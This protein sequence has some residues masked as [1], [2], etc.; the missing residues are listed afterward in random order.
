LFETGHRERESQTHHHQAFIHRMQYISFVPITADSAAPQAIFRRVSLHVAPVMMLLYFVAFLDRVN[1]SFASLTMNHDLGI[2]ETVY[3]L[4]AG[5]FFLGYMLLAVPSNHMLVRVGAPRWMGL[6]MVAWG[7]VGCSM[8]FVHGPVG[9]VVLRFL[10]GAAESGFFPGVVFYMACWLP[11]SARAGILALL[12]LAVPMSSVIGS[13][14]SAALLRLN[15]FH[16]LAGWQWLF[17]LE[18]IPAIVLGLA[19]PW[20]LETGP[21]EARWLS[22]EEKSALLASMAAEDAPARTR[23]RASYPPVGTL[24][25]LALT[26]FMLMIGLY[27]LG[28]WTP[29]LLTSHGVGLRALGWLNAIPYALAAAGILPWCRLSDRRSERRWTLFTSFSCAAVG[30]VIAA[31]A[32]SVWLCLL[33]LAIAAFGV[34]VSMP[35]FWAASTQRMTALAAA[36][37]IAVINS[38]GNIGGFIG[39]YATGWLLAHTHSYVDGLLGTALAL[40]LGAGMVLYAFAGPRASVP[41]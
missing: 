14:I 24:V 25:P 8:A 3:G 5:I 34:F 30:F 41:A 35:I 2:S 27:E 13:P 9:Y 32:P 7:L 18:A 16:G 40:L 10:L 11:G 28:F 6:L 33:G 4:A 21:A 29:R 22:A 36:L 23:N 26:Y 19:V 15:G 1:I 39:P 20:L 17:L 37:G 12:Y 38:V 31:V